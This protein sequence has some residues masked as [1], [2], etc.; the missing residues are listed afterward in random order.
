VQASRHGGA[1]VIK[2]ALERGLVHASVRDQG[3]GIPRER[4][5]EVFEPFG[6][7]AHGWSPA[8]TGLAIV[9]EV[10]RGHGGTASVEDVEVGTLVLLE[11]PVD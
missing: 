8:T 9:R 3:P 4:R 1:V 11:L 7:G 5:R 10:A 2:I 6:H